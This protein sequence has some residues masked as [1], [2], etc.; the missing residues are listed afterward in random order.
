[1]GPEAYPFH[2]LSSYAR[3]WPVPENRNT[4]PHSL[5]CKAQRARVSRA[6]AGRKAR[7]KRKTA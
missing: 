7:N 3:I 5:T 6:K 4:P 1:M 2:F